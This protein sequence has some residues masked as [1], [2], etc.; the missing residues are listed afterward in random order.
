MYEV[1]LDAFNGPLD[2]LLHLIHKYEIDIYDIP[3]KA[4]TEQYMQYVHAM[5]EVEINI[6]SEYLVMASELLMIKSRLL[7]P[8]QETEN[9][10]EEYS[11]LLTELKK[12]RELYYT[13]SPADLSHLEKETHWDKN[14]TID[15]TQLIVAYQRVKNRVALNTP[16]AV[17]ISKDTFTIQQAT[18][19]VAKHLEKQTSFNFFSLFNFNEPVSK[20]VTHFLAILEMSK[21]G[22]INIEQSNN[23]EDINIIRGVN[24]SIG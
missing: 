6:A 15:L 22:L 11:L 19:V 24:Y 18:E 17:E 23:F 12:E 10:L 13:K 1:K 16:K 7:L 9:D 2:L 20:V 3:M 4:L 5:K 21:A 8:Q 14:Q